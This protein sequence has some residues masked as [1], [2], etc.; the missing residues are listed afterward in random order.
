MTDTTAP[1]TP[2]PT[3]PATQSVSVWAGIASFVLGLLV[4]FGLVSQDMAA[5]LGANLNDIIGAIMTLVGVFGI[6]GALRRKT[7]LTF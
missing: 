1:A 7:A 6:F 3:K 4:Q 5:M 2:I